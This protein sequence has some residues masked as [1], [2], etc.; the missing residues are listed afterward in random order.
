MY[1][2]LEAERDPTI[3]F[4]SASLLLRSSVPLLLTDDRIGG[5]WR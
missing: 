1:A 3:R 5:A 2:S 4:E